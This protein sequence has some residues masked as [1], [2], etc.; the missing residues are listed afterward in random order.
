MRTFPLLFVTLMFSGLALLILLKSGS[1]EVRPW[2][3]VPE[4]SKQLL[5]QNKIVSPYESIEYFYSKGG[6][7]HCGSIQY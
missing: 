7:I 4:S 2:D 1:A 6:C 3:R 5:R